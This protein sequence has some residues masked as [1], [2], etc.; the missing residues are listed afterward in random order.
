[1]FRMRYIPL[2][3]MGVAGLTVAETTEEASAGLS[4]ALE[5]AFRI[6]PVYWDKNISVVDICGCETEATAALLPWPT[7]TGELLELMDGLKYA[8]E[9]RSFQC[10]VFSLVTGQSE[11]DS[12]KML[13]ALSEC[14]TMCDM[15]RIPLRI[16][17]GRDGNWLELTP[18]YPVS[19]ARNLMIPGNVKSVLR[20]ADG[21][22][23]KVF[24]S[25]KDV[26]PLL[27]GSNAEPEPVNIFWKPSTGNL[28]EFVELIEAFHQEDIEYSLH[29]LP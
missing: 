27:K 23:V 3:L 29:L 2:L 1:M 11:P 10:V 13:N 25:L 14:V 18:T 24:S 22:I 8:Y 7:T 15:L 19:T 6:P 17:I 12:S 21:T 4:E 20:E 26:P 5:T 16:A 28:A 9:M